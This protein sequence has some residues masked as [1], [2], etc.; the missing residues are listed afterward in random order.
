MASFNSGQSA[1]L[2]NVFCFS[3]LS[4]M[5][6][7][8]QFSE[9]GWRHPH[10]VLERK[11][12]FILQ[13]CHQMLVLIKEGSSHQPFPNPPSSF[14][15]LSPFLLLRLS[16]TAWSI[17]NSFSSISASS[18]ATSCISISLLP[19]SAWYLVLLV[20]DVDVGSSTV[21]IQ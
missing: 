9:H 1:D 16:T 7:C 20:V 17:A 3:I 10:E 6:S 15:P 18:A 8:N 2:K 13:F 21:K 11:R 4:P 14:P 5:Q 19:A 12:I